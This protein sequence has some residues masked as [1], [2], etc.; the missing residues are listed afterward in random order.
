MIL[1]LGQGVPC[2][3]VVEHTVDTR[4]MLQRAGLLLL[5]CPSTR[6]NCKHI[7][8]ATDLPETQAILDYWTVRSCCQVCSLMS[9]EPVA[10]QGLRASCQAVWP[11]G[12]S[13]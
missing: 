5:P 1:P 13:I 10:A 9:P 11:V 7:C 3:G 12:T 8:F 2:H 6:P 4:R